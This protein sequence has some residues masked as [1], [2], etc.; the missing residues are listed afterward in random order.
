MT[1]EEKN[2]Y[3]LDFLNSLSDEFINNLIEKIDIYKKDHPIIDRAGAIFRMDYKNDDYL[4][5]LLYNDLVI[6]RNLMEDNYKGFAINYN[7][8]KNLRKL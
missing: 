1:K 2:N 5:Y 3:F 8:F 6:V 7:L 4:F